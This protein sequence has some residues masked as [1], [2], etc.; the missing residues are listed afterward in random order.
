MLRWRSLDGIRMSAWLLYVRTLLRCTT[1]AMWRKASPT[2]RPAQVM[3]GKQP[4]PSPFTTP[5]LS[6]RWVGLPAARSACFLL[7][8]IHQAV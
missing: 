5:C 4:H 1:G 2:S 3:W 8:R 7:R 6:P